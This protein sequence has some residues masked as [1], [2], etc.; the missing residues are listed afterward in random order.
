M[1]FREITLKLAVDSNKFKQITNNLSKALKA[2]TAELEMLINKS[3]Q[4]ENE[5]KVNYL[6]CVLIAFNYKV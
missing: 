2:A 6:F 1:L 3:H 4:L 5:T